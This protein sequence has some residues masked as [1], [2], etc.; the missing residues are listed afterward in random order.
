MTGTVY[1]NAEVEP[2]LAV[3]PTDPNHLVGMWQ[4]DRWSNGSARGL[5][6]AVSFDGGASW[7]RSPVPVSRCGGG[8]AANGGDFARA[9][10]PWVSIAP[11]GTVYGMSLST[12]GAEFTAGSRNA[13]LVTRSFDRG[14]TWEAPKAVGSDGALFFNDKGAITADPTNPALAYAVWDRL[15]SLGNG[16]AQFARTTDGGNTWEAARAIYNPGGINQTIGNEIVV[17]PDGTLV[18]LFTQIDTDGAGNHTSVLGVLRSTDHGATWSTPFRI[19]D[20]LA[21]GTRD[22]HTNA[23]VRDGA[24]IAQM[25][26]APNGTLYV[27]WQ[28]A[29]FSNGAIDAIVIAR[30]TDG[31]RTWSAPRR[32]NTAIGVAAFTPSVHVAPDGTVG[33]SYYDFR[34]NTPDTGSLATDYWLARSD[35]GGLTWVESRIA[36]P[37]DLD[38][39]PNAGGFFLGDYQSLQV[40]GNVFVPFFVATTGNIANRTDVYAAPAVSV[41]ALGLRAAAATTLRWEAA[42]A[43]PLAIPDAFRERVHARIDRDMRKRIRNWQGERAA[44]PAT[45]PPPLRVIRGDGKTR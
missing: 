30:S 41:A 14:R 1:P 34:S 35:N 42:P 21:V 27:V 19:A 8:T 7:T 25:A 10:D 37:F 18:D 45:I 15:N 20:L 44:P 23:A 43:A 32:L 31:G 40:R 12:T 28:D 11:N 38:M 13:M 33:V 24:D 36:S 29:R 16:P 39:A 3:D 17:L 4:Q 22:P 26:V 5:V 2:S 6:S 9:T